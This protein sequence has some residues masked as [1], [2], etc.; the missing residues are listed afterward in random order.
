MTLKLPVPRA[1]L[2]L[3][4]GVLFVTAAQA[5][6]DYL[7]VGNANQ[8]RVVIS[9]NQTLR[10]RVPDAMLSTNMAYNLFELQDWDRST[11]SVKG[12]VR[13]ILGE[14]PGALYRYP[15]GLPANSANTQNMMLPY[16]T[17]LSRRQTGSSVNAFPLFA[18]PEYIDFIQEVT[19]GRPWYTLNLIGPGGTERPSWQVANDNRD[20]ASAI[21]ART[22]NQ[23]VRYYQLG[24]ELDRNSYQWSHSKYISRSRDS[25]NAISQVDSSAR[26]VPFMREFD[27]RYRSP[28][29]GTSRAQDYF[30]DVMRAFPQIRDYSL[31]FYYDGRLSPSAP[32]VTIP[33]MID[34]VEK[35]LT[36]AQNAR[37]ASY[38]IW[39]TEHGK[40]FFLSGGTPASGT[41]LS[42][43]VS[44]GDF[45]L[46]MYQIPQV[47][48]A[49]L[50]GL[51]GGERFFFYSNNQPTALLQAMRVLARQPYKRLLRAKTFSPNTSGYQG[52]YDVRAIA[53]TN[54]S[55]N[56]LGVSAVNRSRNGQVIRIEYPPL[57]NATRSMRRFS[58]RGANGENPANVERNYQATLTPAATAKQ[59]TSQ[60]F[61]WV[62]LPPSSV[63]SIVFE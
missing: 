43:G 14:F 58:V 28:V 1:A 27:W 24:N 18:L 32:F 33:D 17:R 31:H 57:A 9:P 20:L 54:S 42:A 48:G 62:W 35:S 47:Q 2:A 37:S 12:S 61:T 41:S 13:S 39:I 7:E 44:V 4:L 16:A 46:S 50:Q 5:A 59:F 55:G 34:K 26:F 10:A 22:G 15:G 60:G 45:L 38:G 51:E 52:G 3:C 23:A 63:S 40:R 21:V 49:M 11:R 36:L 6:P 19:W 25:I 8:A 53:F 30:N 29:S 56:Q